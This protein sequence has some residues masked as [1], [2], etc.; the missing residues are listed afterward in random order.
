M[1][2]PSAPSSTTSTAAAP[3]AASA[4][5]A[6]QPQRLS[7]LTGDRFCAACGF[8]LV[9]Q[10]VVREPHY[11]MLMVRCPECGT[12][13]AMQEYPMLGRWANRWA[14]VLALALM[15]FVTLFTVGM[16]FACWGVSIPAVEAMVRPCTERLGEEHV[17]WQKANAVAKPAAPPATATAPPA[18]NAESTNGSPAP[19]PSPTE[20]VE[21]A[22]IDP[23]D[24]AVAPI[25]PIPAPASQVTVTINGVPVTGNAA[26]VAAIAAANTANTA[27][28]ANTTP[29]V[30]DWWY[31]YAETNWTRSPEFRP[32]LDRVR[33]WGANAVDWNGLR[34]LA[35]SM[36]VAFIIGILY[37]VL[38]LGSSRKKALLIIPIVMG[39]SITWMLIDLT[40]QEFWGGSLSD[41]AR[42]TLG[43]PLHLVVFLFMAYA[44]AMGVWLGRPIARWFV[45]LMLPPRLRGSLADLWLC[46]GKSPPSGALALPKRPS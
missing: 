25:N 39:L 19:D 36:P 9:G 21:P 30:Q 15:V 37:S 7:I 11:Q 28:T 26:A 38:M 14:R 33:G 3:A 41:L 20:P 46:D 27:T 23:A 8:N 24:P 42:Q 32:A 45:A 13:S 43:V 31:R 10:S 40:T 17:K 35:L 18:A 29:D 1:T 44:M 34:W 6:G 5:P 16:S 22:I 2:E 12:P 4:P